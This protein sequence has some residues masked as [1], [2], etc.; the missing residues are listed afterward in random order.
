[1]IMG[2]GRKGLGAGTGARMAATRVRS[3]AERGA[4]GLT[5]LATAL[6][7]PGAVF[8]AGSEGLA[9]VVITG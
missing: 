6:G 2:S 8:R 9:L 3:G 7:I 5:E 4:A 1:M